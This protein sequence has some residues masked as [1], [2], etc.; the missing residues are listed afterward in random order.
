MSLEEGTTFWSVLLMWRIFFCSIF[1][2]FAFST[3]VN[4]IF[5]Y[6]GEIFSDLE[7]NEMQSRSYYIQVLPGQH[8]YFERFNETLVSYE[9]FELPIFF[10]VGIIG[11]LLGA[12]FVTVQVKVA[13]FRK[14][15]GNCFENLS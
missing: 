10:G 1:S 2:S 4:I 14:R 15:Y 11:G 5:G 8:T 12:F 6:S 3:A 9:Y 13:V 7:K